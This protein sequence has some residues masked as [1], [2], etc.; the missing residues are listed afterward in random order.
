MVACPGV[1]TRSQRSPQQQSSTSE[2]LESGWDSTEQSDQL[3]ARNHVRTQA[4]VSADY[5]VPLDPRVSIFPQQTSVTR[6]AIGGKY[7]LPRWEELCKRICFPKCLLPS[8]KRHGVHKSRIGDC[9]DSL[10]KCLGNE[11]IPESL[12]HVHYSLRDREW[13]Y[14]NPIT[15]VFHANPLLPLPWFLK[16][17]RMR[18]KALE[19]TAKWKKK[20]I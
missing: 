17:L 3:E 10:A 8:F 15:T 16:R 4:H 6:A 11:C 9:L 1:T 20:V 12:R 5:E 19:R 14:L 18:Q 7:S 13:L 2:D